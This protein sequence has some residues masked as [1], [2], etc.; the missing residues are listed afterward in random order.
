M[1]NKYIFLTLTIFAIFIS[2][3]Q[4]SCDCDSRYSAEIFSDVSIETVTYSDVHGLQMDIYQP[5]GDSCTERPL[6][7]FAHGGTFIFGSKNNPTM[8]DLCE[9]FAKRGYVTASINYRLAAESV[10]FFQSFT[11]YTNTEDAYDVVLKAVMDGKAAVRYFRKN[12][13]ES[14]NQY[15]IDPAQIWGGGNSAGGVLFMH[16]GNIASLEEFTSPLDNNRAAIAE[17]IVNSLGGFEGNS[18]NAGYSSEISG[19]I[20]L[21]GALHRSEYVDQNDV[22]SV[23]CHG[24]ADGVVPYDC[25]GFQN[26]PSYDQLCGGGALFPEFQSLGIN[27]D[28]KTFEGDGHCPWD[29]NSSKK[30]E[31]IAFVSEFIYNNLDCSVECPEGFVDIDGECE[32]IAEGCID[33]AACNYDE[34]A[35]IDDESCYYALEGYDCDVNPFIGIWETGYEEPNF[36]QFFDDGTLVGYN[37]DLELDCL[38]GPL[39]PEDDEGN[40]YNTYTYSPLDNTLIFNFPDSDL[41]EILDSSTGMIEITDGGCEEDSVDD[42]ETVILNQVDALPSDV[43][44]D[45]DVNV[46]EIL[47]SKKLVKKITILGQE[48][49]KSSFELFIY[50]DGTV[51]KKYVKK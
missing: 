21:A 24:D 4:S 12:H 3:S 27:T 43:I 35:N 11:F 6:L 15:G 47:S 28:L 10:G 22:P 48:T 46:S 9:T 20:S 33:Q 42:C 7:I 19:V 17:N 44:C 32:L 26:N 2:H 14:N 25:N 16:V 30:D 45:D 5:V 38:I 34:L 29:S 41:L 23:F 49:L 13:A 18:G 31:M 40:T 50:S 39:Y 8:E 51:E 37:Y 36:I 1:K